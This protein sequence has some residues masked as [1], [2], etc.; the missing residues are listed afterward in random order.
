[1]QKNVI[2]GISGATGIIYAIS[3]LKTLRQKN[4]MTQLVITKAA[5]R[6]RAYETSLTAKQLHELANI[7]FPIRHIN[8]ELVHE[9]TTG[10]IIAPCSMKTL[11]EVA[12]QH[13]DNLLT[14]SAAQILVKNLPLILLTRETPLHSGH[15]RNMQNVQRLGARIFPP[16]I[17]SNYSSI[18]DMISDTIDSIIRSM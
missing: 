15:L 4:F 9:N 6:T 3:L 10:M 5:E 11:A 14:K 8:Q 12:Y 13:Q 2:I 16:M 1:M 17:N 7:Y 18:S